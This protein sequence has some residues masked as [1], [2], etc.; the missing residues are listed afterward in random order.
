MSDTT[1]MHPRELTL[2][3]ILEEVDA[4][5]WTSENEFY[6][7]VNYWRLVDFMSR[8]VVYFND[9]WFARSGFINGESNIA[10]VNAR[11]QPMHIC[12]DIFPVF[13]NSDID[14]E[15]LFPKDQYTIS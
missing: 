7:W 6:V 4:F 11:I 10:G 3:K 1:T 13:Q 15:K 14:L 2:Q 5:G 9:E 8:M 12:I